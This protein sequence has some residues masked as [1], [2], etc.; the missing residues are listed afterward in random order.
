MSNNL[1]KRGR[2]LRTIE[3]AE[4]LLGRELSQSEKEIFE[5]GFECGREFELEKTIAQLINLI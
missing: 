2:I 3:I 5:Y 1:T 4:H